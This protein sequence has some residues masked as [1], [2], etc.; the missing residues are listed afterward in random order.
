MSDDDFSIIVTPA[1]PQS[2]MQVTVTED[3]WVSLN[4][5]LARQFAKKPVQLRFNRDLTVLQIAHAEG[6]EPDHFIF[7]K[8]GRKP[9]P[10]ASALLKGVHMPFPVVFRGILL[11]DIEKWRGERQEN[12]TKKH[13]PTTRSTKK[14]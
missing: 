10:N 1:I 11:D 2:A 8:S 7:P 9:I 13:S 5:K 3:G 12:P 14:K 4:S 6:S